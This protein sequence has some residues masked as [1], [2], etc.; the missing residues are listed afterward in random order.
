MFRRQLW[1]FINARFRNTM[2]AKNNDS[3]EPNVLDFDGNWV[4]YVE[5]LERWKESQKEDGSE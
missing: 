3:K 1:K 2:V 5:A 4:K